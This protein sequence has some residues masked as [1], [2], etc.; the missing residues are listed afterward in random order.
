[1]IVFRDAE[2]DDDGHTSNFIVE[3]LVFNY[4][5]NSHFVEKDLSGLPLDYEDGIFCSALLLG[6]LV[7]QSLLRKDNN[8]NYSAQFV[9]LMKCLC[10]CC[11]L[12]QFSRV[13][14]S[15]FGVSCSSAGC[16]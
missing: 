1:M 8:L 13:S 14:C 3:M 12:L 11:S 7:R 16:R 10:I 2:D 5:L 9:E 6:V 15:V 4:G